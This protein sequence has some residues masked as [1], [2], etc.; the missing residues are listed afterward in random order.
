MQGRAGQQGFG[1]R[2]KQLLELSKEWSN[3]IIQFDKKMSI[4]LIL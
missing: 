3:K 1:P 2:A 4:K